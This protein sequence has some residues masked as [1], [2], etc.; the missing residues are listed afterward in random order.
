MSRR[1]SAKPASCVTG[2]GVPVTPS[3]APT[4][5][6]LIAAPLSLGGA[7]TTRSGSSMK[8]ITWS[9][10]RST[11]AG[12]WAPLIAASLT[13][14]SRSASNSGRA[15][16]AGSTDAPLASSIGAYSVPRTGESWLKRF[17]TAG[18][19]RPAL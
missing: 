4:L 19:V 16:K 12:V 7:A 2:I 5:M 13:R 8:G 11:S 18:L 17:C 10:E 14:T 15:P 6:A 9:I 1:A 3:R